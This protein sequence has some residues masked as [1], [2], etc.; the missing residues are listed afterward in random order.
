[1]CKRWTVWIG[2]DWDT[3]LHQITQANFSNV[4]FKT[5][6]NTPL[7]LTHPQKL[8]QEVLKSTKK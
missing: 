3:E 8:Y 5:F 4:I 7:T 6:R 2:L 1:M